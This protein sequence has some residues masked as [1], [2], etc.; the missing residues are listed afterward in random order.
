MGGSRPGRR[1]YASWG[2]MSR[3]ADEG[4]VNIGIK[5]IAEKETVRESWRGSRWLP[6]M[7]WETGQGMDD[8][9]G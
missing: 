2:R 1:S 4:S 9:C 6:W 7:H 5:V 3:E 8:V